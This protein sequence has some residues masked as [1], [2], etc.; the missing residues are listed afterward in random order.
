MFDSGPTSP[1]GADGSTAYDSNSTFMGALNGGGFVSAPKTVLN[2]VTGTQTFAPVSSAHAIDTG[3]GTDPMWGAGYSIVAGTNLTCTDCHDAHGSS[4][5][6]ALKDL[7]N[8]NVVGGYV[9]AD[10]ETPNPVVWSAEEGY[11]TIGWL[12]HSAGAAQMELYKPNYTTA[13]YKYNGIASNNPTLASGTNLSI[14]T[15]CSA[16]H[17]R[18]DEKTGMYDYGAYEFAGMSGT[19][20]AGVTATDGVAPGIGNRN[21][22]RHPVNI[23]LVAGVGPTRALQAEVI[24]STVLPLEYTSLDSSFA[25]PDGPWS[26]DDYMGCLTCHRAHGVSSDMT[27]WAEA[28]YVTSATAVVTWYPEPLT[29]PIVSGV[30]PNFSSA[31]LRTDN[32]GVCERC[33]NK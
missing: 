20:T 4:N 25:G 3:S 10:G 11:P 6:R 32:R 13:Q 12:K 19:V 30:N 8:G 26:T 15:W 29:Q 31:L 16:C 27:G 1:D 17:E 14:S 23:S 21:R 5:Y 2:D 24:T 7:V 22:H 18:Y 9:G 28:S 33:H